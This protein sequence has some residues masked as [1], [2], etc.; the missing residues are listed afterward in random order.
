MSRELSLASPSS[1]RDGL[2]KLWRKFTSAFS[3]TA[4]QTGQFWIDGKPIYR[5]VVDLGA[6]PDTTTKNV[7][8]GL[9]GIGEIVS[10]GGIAIDDASEFAAALPLPNDVV[11]LSIGTTNVSVVTAS[12]LSGYDQAYAV[13]EYTL[14]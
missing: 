12:D 2:Y 3:T 13:V 5:K 9:T 8:H 10:L 11:A 4:H 6:L 14:A 7:A 1:L